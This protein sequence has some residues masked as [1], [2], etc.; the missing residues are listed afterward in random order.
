MSISSLSNNISALVAQLNI[1]TATSSVQ[2]NV[3]AL[4][5]GSRIVSAATDVAALSTG[6]ALSAQVN[7]INTAL[8]VSSQASSLLQVADGALSQIQTIIQRQQTIAASAQSGSLT[9]TQRGF[10]DQ[11]FQN[12]SSQIDQLANST[13]FNGVNL[14]NGNISGKL[15]FS[16]NTTDSTAASLA[17]GGIMTLNGSVATGDTVTIDGVTVTFSS[18]AQGTTGAAGKVVIGASATDSAANLATYLNGLGAPQFANLQFH[19]AAGVI[20]ANYT[21]GTLLGA[22]SITSSTSDTTNI[23][24]TGSASI[25]ATT[26]PVTTNADG[27]SVDR[28]STFGAATGSILVS[29]GGTAKT[30]GAAIDVSTL[31]NNASFI[32]NFGG[33]NISA[34]TASYT[35]SA[36]TANFSVT[37]GGITYTTGAVTLTAAAAPIVATF[38]GAD[39]T[40]AAKGGTFKL[41]FDGNGQVFTSQSQLDSI[42]SELN[43]AVAGISVEQNRTVAGVTTGNVVTVGGVQ[44]ANLQGLSAQ[45]KG[46]DFTNPTISSITVSAPGTGSTDAK[47]SAVINGHTFT[48]VSGIG[49]SINKN[50]VIAL[51]D[52]S[53]P[54]Q[55]FSL[56]TGNTVIATST[57]AALDISSSDKASA[58][59]DALEKAFGIDKAGASL[60]FQA[61]AASTDTIGV[62]IGSATTSSLFS[63]QSLDV[64]TLSSATKAAGVLDSAL[65][66]VSSLRATVGA[67]EERFSYASNALQSAAQNEGAAKSNLLDTDVA[68][69]STAFA[70]SQVQLQAGIAVLAQANQLQQSLLK[71]IQ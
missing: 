22:Q 24:G 42:T 59:Q 39:S 46:S 13:T 38:T 16:T 28:Y 62:S 18:S 43:Q 70:T 29:G 14:I 65:N 4:S 57:T 58:I 71:L 66:T 69:T 2:N 44:V 33:G 21:G 52:T 54:S 49:T 17:S 36:N 10:L 11:E 50:T 27:L 61:G 48:S 6:T 30:A 25:A 15:G 34:I 26:T 68:A 51:Q 41:T 40:G 37:A 12:L 45:F 9:D 23:T 35:G 19:A 56:V 3:T 32:G 5:S 63:G 47:I 31:K 67:L 55:T 60:Q 1:G 7:S 8:S 64:K 20:T 53:D